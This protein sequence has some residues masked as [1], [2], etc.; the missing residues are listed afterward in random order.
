VVDL[1]PDSQLFLN[2]QPTA[3]SSATQMFSTIPLEAGPQY[4]VD[5][6]AEYVDNGRRLKSEKRVEIRP[7]LMSRVSFAEPQAPA[8]LVMDGA[9]RRSK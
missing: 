6:R 8:P 5:V 3:V 4:W 9:T 7:G 1:R 2:G